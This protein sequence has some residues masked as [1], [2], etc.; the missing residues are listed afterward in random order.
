MVWAWPRWTQQALPL[1][2]ETGAQAFDGGGRE[3]TVWG[4]LRWLHSF[5]KC[6][7]IIYYGPNLIPST[8]E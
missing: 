7:L 5:Y 2:F 3:Q 4:R 6:F 1:S 8:K